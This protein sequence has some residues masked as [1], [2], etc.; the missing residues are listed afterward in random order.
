M[1]DREVVARRVDQKSPSA[2][3]GVVSF[4]GL[5]PATESASRSKRS[6]KATG[7]GPEKFLQRLLKKGNYRFQVNVS[8]LPGRPDVVFQREKIAIFCDGD[9][10]HGR[11]WSSRRAKLSTG[12]NAE[13]W[14][15]KIEM[16]M[17]RDIRHR[18]QL[19]RAG[20]KVL[21]V[22]EGDLRENPSASLIKIQA[23]LKERK[24][25]SA[26]QR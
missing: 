14:I 17:A 15:R 13:Y 2:K 3:R 11:R 21:K 7:T 23:A 5:H 24:S 22:W 9:F 16:N 18:R 10:W 6:N 25:R 26:D 1:K 12:H 20:W 19:R 8:D 4:A